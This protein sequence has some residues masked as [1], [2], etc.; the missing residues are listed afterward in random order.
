MRLHVSRGT[1]C[2]MVA[3]LLDCCG[4]L[5]IYHVSKGT[6]FPEVHPRVV[7]KLHD[8]VLHGVR[9]SCRVEAYGEKQWLVVS[10]TVAS[11]QDWVAARAANECPP[12]LRIDIELVG[13]DEEV[14]L[15]L[16]GVND[17][18][19]GFGNASGITQQACFHDIPAGIRIEDISKVVLGFGTASGTAW[20][21][22]S[23]DTERDN[24]PQD[25]PTDNDS[26][27]DAPAPPPA[28]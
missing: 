22:S 18:A 4:C 15:S 2:V 7:L 13:I 28:D 16:S 27:S 17:V 6:A 12:D 19:G 9:F 20:R 24:T 8:V 23:G 10:E 11:F 25:Q 21:E 14:V 5:S 1:R 26:A 3:F